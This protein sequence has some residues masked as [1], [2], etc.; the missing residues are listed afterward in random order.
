MCASQPGLWKSQSS[1]P[2]PC[3]C[4]RP[5]PL[6]NRQG[7]LWMTTITCGAAG[8]EDFCS[9]FP[10]GSGT[11]LPGAGRGFMQ[12]LVICPAAANPS[13]CASSIRST[14]RRAVASPCR[15]GTSGYEGTF[16]QRTGR[17]ARRNY[18][19]CQ[20][21]TPEPEQIPHCAAPDACT[22][23]DD[24]HGLPRLDLQRVGANTPSP[25]LTRDVF[26]QPAFLTSHPRSLSLIASGITERGHRG[27][28]RV[29][30]WSIGGPQSAA[31]SIRRKL[32]TVSTARAA[33]AGWS[34]NS[35]ESVIWL[36]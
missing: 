26:S 13:L 1:A 4:S 31:G 35:R 15:P 9:D 18:E 23:A 21:L 22:F 29:D 17:A 12:P 14:S 19:A 6:L 5:S 34:P 16:G 25:W 32:R 33:P 7:S 10:G 24:A 36:S 28:S 8:P 2:S 30:E 20:Q 27:L 3:A 11:R